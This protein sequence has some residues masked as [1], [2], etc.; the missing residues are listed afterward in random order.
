MKVMVL[1][2]MTERCHSLILFHILTLKS[3]QFVWY[4]QANGTITLVRMVNIILKQNNEQY[5]LDMKNLSVRRVDTIITL[6]IGTNRLE[7]TV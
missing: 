5:L 1:L 3:K 4:F 2:L 7:Q 6:N